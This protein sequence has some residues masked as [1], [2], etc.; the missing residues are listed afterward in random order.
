MIWISSVLHWKHW[1]YCKMFLWQTENNPV[2]SHF[3]TTNM[4][5]TFY[6]YKIH[7]KY[8]QRCITTLDIGY[9]WAKGKISSA[10]IQRTFYDGCCKSN[11]RLLMTFNVIKLFIMI[12]K[13]VTTVKQ[14]PPMFENWNGLLD[15]HFTLTRSRWRHVLWIVCFVK[16]IVS[17][18]T[19]PPCQTVKTHLTFIENCSQWGLS[20][21]WQSGVMLPRLNLT[22]R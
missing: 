4:M 10:N 19:H 12:I 3:P 7:D 21:N 2:I 5:F 11:D 22:R 20:A 6:T 1:M 14:I 8:I 13:T 9:V 15:A 18:R 17:S 16:K